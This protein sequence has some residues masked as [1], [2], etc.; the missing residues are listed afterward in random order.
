MELTRRQVT[1]MGLYKEP[2]CVNS[3]Q[4]KL[5]LQDN[6]NTSLILCS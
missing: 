4:N 6:D 2:P 5:H 1:M 3:F